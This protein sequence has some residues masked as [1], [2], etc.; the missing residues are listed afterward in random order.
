MFNILHD[1]GRP[2][3]FVG[4]ST[5]S[6]SIYSEIS[7]S[8]ESIIVAV[9]DLDN[10]NQSWYD[11]YQFITT[12]SDIVFKEQT[13]AKL[14]ERQVHY[15][16]VVHNSNVFYPTTVIGVGTFINAYN[17][18]MPNDHVAIGNHCIVGTHS[19]IGHSC[20]IEDLC[21]I[22]SFC[23]LQNCLIQRGSI[24]GIRSTIL[25]KVN[26]GRIQIPAYS[27]IMVESR[28]TE[29]LPVAGT[30]AG[31]RKINDETSRVARIL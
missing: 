20:V 9:E 5:L 14:N 23:F 13:I 2:L 11:Q 22:S 16:S 24:I 28:V 8:R 25:G 29:S 18:T 3:C 15:F 31:K 12:T 30:Y 17:A 21:H 19:A 10:Y 6:R 27:N 1:N 7:Q 4:H 26:T